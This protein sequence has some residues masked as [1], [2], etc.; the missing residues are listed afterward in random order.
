MKKTLSLTLCILILLVTV[1][2]TVSCGG[3]KVALTSDNYDDYLTLNVEITNFRHEDGKYYADITIV[4][5]RAANVE[6]ENATLTKKPSSAL[7]QLKGDKG[8][9]IE[10]NY[11]GASRTT[12]VYS[13][14]LD[15]SKQ[16]QTI[17]SKYK[18]GWDAE[19][20]VI[21]P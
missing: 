11:T 20:Y 3:K 6:F 18:T 19:G 14:P 10:L 13:S 1:L 5:D 16:Y 21:V 12:F 17:I 2:S 9:E 8:Q 4:T 7:A 15:F